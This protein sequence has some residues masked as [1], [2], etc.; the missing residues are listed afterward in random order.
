MTKYESLDKA[1]QT[2]IAR[3]SISNTH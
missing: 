1:V 3:V 2:D